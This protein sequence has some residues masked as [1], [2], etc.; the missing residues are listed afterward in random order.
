[1]TWFSEVLGSCQH[2]WKTRC[3][4]MYLT[5]GTQAWSFWTNLFLF[6][7]CL[8]VYKYNVRNSSRRMEGRRKQSTVSIIQKCYQRN[9]RRIREAIIYSELL[10]KQNRWQNH[11]F[12]IV[13]LKLKYQTPLSQLAF[14][15][16]GA[17]CDDMQYN[18]SAHRHWFSNWKG[19]EIFKWHSK[20]FVYIQHGD[21]L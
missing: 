13:L 20:L 17:G 11:L 6:Y 5:L 21:R 9:H 3:L 10:C 14:G 1:M 16:V 8:S 2:F 12:L 7:H 4:F 18:S 15:P 19:A